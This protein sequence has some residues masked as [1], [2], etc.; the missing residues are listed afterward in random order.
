ML[1]QISLA[2]AEANTVH[3]TFEEVLG[4]ICRFMAWPLGHIYIWSEATNTLVSSHVWYM[5]DENSNAPFRALSEATQFH[6]DEGTM[7]EVWKRGR[8]SIF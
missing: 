8:P 5:A 6:L 7:G 2:V 4:H 1:Q 3:T